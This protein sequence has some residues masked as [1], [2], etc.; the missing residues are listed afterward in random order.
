MI[1]DMKQQMQDMEEKMKTMKANEDTI[2]ASLIAEKDRADKAELLVASEKERANGFES[3]LK[4]IESDRRKQVLASKNL[5]A[6]MIEKKSNFIVNASETEFNDYVSELD[7][8]AALFGKPAVVKE[9]VASEKDSS[10][11]IIKDVIL[12]DNGKDTKDESSNISLLI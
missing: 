9:V 4:T 11:D 1:D 8:Y 10:K 2:N 12:T 3:K 7:V 6:E 5:T